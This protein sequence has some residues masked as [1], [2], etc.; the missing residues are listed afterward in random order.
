MTGNKFKNCKGQTFKSLVY[1][2]CTQGRVNHQ[3]ID[4]NI[5]NNSC[6]NVKH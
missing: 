1:T 3:D 6:A 4:E 2:T 5:P